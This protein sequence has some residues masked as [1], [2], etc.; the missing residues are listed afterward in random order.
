MALKEH[1]ASEHPTVVM[2]PTGLTSI[3]WQG[4]DPDQPRS[5][6]YHSAES[7]HLPVMKAGGHAR[8]RMCDVAGGL[9]ETTMIGDRLPTLEDRV[10]FI[11]VCPYF[12]RSP[13][14]RAPD[15]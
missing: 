15:M 2:L 14:T 9:R 6:H 8:S 13:K 11:T 1:H 12:V 10:I 4:C 3:C 5:L 7:L